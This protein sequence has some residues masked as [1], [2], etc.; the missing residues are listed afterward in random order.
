MTRT[1]LLLLGIFLLTP[2]SLTTQEL[3]NNESKIK[4]AALE[5]IQNQKYCAL[6][7]V[8]KSGYPQARTMEALPMEKD[9]IAW[10]GTNKNSRKVDDIRN[11]QVVTVYYADDSGNGYAVLSGFAEIIDDEVE[12]NK[13]WLDHWEQFY[14]DRESTYVLIKVNPTKLEVVSYKHGLTGDSISWRAPH[15]EFDSVEK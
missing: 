9:F 14:P 6:I 3:S 1:L 2:N 15:I 10:F 12:K 11:N 4:Q 5:I 8:G 13:R 7:T